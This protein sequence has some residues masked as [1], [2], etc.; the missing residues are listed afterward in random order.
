M[1]MV[2]LGT[3]SADALALTSPDVSQ[4]GRISDEQVY[5]G[6]ACKGQNASPRFPGPARQLRPR[7]LQS[8]CLIRTRGLAPVSGAG[9]RGSLS[10]CLIRARRDG[11]GFGTGGSSTSPPTS[12][13]C[14]RGREAASGLPGGAVQGRTGFDAN[15]YGGPCPPPGKAHHYE[16]TVYALD[17]DKLDVDQDTSP[18][19][20][21]LKLQGHILAKASLT[22]V[23][24]R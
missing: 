8:A 1:A 19:D 12:R 13:R 5:N 15:A 4:G 17:V 22:G 10:A 11:A 14:R 21:G 23:W 20:I 3:T 6:G 18:A 2:M 7:A 9:P 16:I 24:G